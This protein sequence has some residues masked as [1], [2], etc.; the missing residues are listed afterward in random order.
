MLDAVDRV[1]TFQNILKRIVDRILACLDRQALMTHILQGN[2]LIT[3]LILCQLDSRNMFILVMIWTISAS[4]HTVIGEIQRCKHND[5][6]PV[7]LLLDLHGKLSDLTVDLRIIALH[8]NGCLFVGNSLC[9]LRFLKNLANQ[10]KIIFV[11]FRIIKR[12]QNLLMIDKFFC[13]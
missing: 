3:D 7:K 2:D 13:L 1:D 8:Q 4:I 6:M 11:L 5:T 10:R 9:L 12:F